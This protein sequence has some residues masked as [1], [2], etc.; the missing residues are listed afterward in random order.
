VGQQ[1]LAVK[2][3]IGSVLRATP[4]LC[5]PFLLKIIETNPETFE[6]CSFLPAQL[7]LLFYL[8]GV[9]VQAPGQ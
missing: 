2:Y 3:N 8:T 4:F 6:K 5:C 9:Q 1:A 7:N